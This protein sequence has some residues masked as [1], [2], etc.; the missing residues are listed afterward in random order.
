MM[1]CKRLE[2]TVPL[3]RE[4]AKEGLKTNKTNTHKDINLLKV[5]PMR[6]YD[7]GQDCELIAMIMSSKEDEFGTSCRMEQVGTEEIPIY[8]MKCD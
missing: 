3:F 8:E 2:K 6:V 4:L 7:L 5:M 1:F